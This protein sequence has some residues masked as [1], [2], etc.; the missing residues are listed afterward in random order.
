MSADSAGLSLSYTGPSFFLRVMLAQGP[1]NL[2]YLVPVLVCVLPK[3]A[4]LILLQHLHAIPLFMCLNLFNPSSSDGSVGCLHH[5]R[6]H[7]QI[8]LMSN[9]DFRIYFH[10]TTLRLSSN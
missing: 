5:C 2:L 4:L 3:R 10:Y 7:S 9:Q 8:F 1:C 6:E